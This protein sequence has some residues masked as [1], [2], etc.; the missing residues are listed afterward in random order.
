MSWF[1]SL[2]SAVTS[3]ARKAVQWVSEGIKAVAQFASKAIDTVKAGWDALKTQ[4]ATPAT[5]AAQKN[6]LPRRR[7]EALSLAAAA[8]RR[9]VAE[10]AR[11]QAISEAD[12]RRA[13]AL[14][15]AAR[16]AELER[17]RRRVEQQ[18]FL[19][20]AR[21]LE[22]DLRQV[23]NSDQLV[24]FEE[25]ARVSLAEMII[26]HLKKK[27]ATLDGWCSLSP[28][29]LDAAYALPALAREGGSKTEAAYHQEKLNAYCIEEFGKPLAVL[30]AESFFEPYN[31][32]ALETEMELKKQ[33]QAQNH[34][35]IERRSY[36]AKKVVE[37]LSVADSKHLEKLGVEIDLGRKSIDENQR[38]QIDLDLV[39]GV[40]EGLLEIYSGA[41]DDPV[42]I[43]EGR[44]VGRVLLAWQ[45]RKEPLTA[46]DRMSLS[47]FAGCYVN[48]A[49]SR[50][51]QL[52]QR[53]LVPVSLTA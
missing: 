4:R 11:R 33:R 22:Q 16:N 8:D 34:L 3:V 25:Y 43:D 44:E 21:D 15:A 36:D 46:A 32:Q 12:M 48:R 7:A 13:E 9:L 35:E 18:A 40:N 37:G 6:D 39:T 49:R 51:A 50:T 17:E 1:S 29:E 52:S 28:I 47:D 41:E 2:V 20:S 26:K 10:I 24:D 19:Q 14:E 31:L 53:R 38:R 27:A 45:Q 30:A 5:S 42:M 23:M